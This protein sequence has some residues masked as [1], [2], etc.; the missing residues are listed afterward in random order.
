MIINFE[1][2]T[3]ELTEEEKKAVPRIIKGMYNRYGERNA[4][5]NRR[6]CELLKKEGYKLSG[7]RV[8]KIFNFIRSEGIIRNIVTTSKGII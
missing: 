2:Y 3:H 8:R 6:I 5:T 4:I 7:P 1:D